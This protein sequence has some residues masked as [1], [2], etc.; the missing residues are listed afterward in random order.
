MYPLFTALPLV[1]AALSVPAAATDPPD[2]IFTAFWSYACDMGNASVTS[3]AY[4]EQW[5]VSP[6]LSFH[7]FKLSRSLTS[8]ETLSFA[9]PPINS[10][11]KEPTPPGEPRCAYAIGSITQKDQ[12]ALNGN[13]TNH[14]WQMIGDMTCVMLSA[15]NST[16][17]INPSPISTS[18][19][20][21]I[22]STTA[23]SNI[24]I[25]AAAATTTH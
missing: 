19:S 9:R 14:C 3:T 13:V 24:S 20:S 17:G 10:V 6:N 12:N 1:L 22:M 4:N 8:K 23:T 18:S 25:T 11:F 5:T 15:D 2:L 21:S 7:S 16:I